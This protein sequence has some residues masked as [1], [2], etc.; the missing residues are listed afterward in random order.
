MYIVVGVR[1]GGRERPGKVWCTLRNVV[2]EVRVTALPQALPSAPRVAAMEK[3]WRLW[4]VQ[5]SLPCIFKD[6]QLL[7]FC[8]SPLVML[9]KL[10]FEESQGICRTSQFAS[11]ICISVNH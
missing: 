1:A 9:T 2:I 8:L 10:S 7:E 11:A 4:Q 6:Q 3:Q 5:Q